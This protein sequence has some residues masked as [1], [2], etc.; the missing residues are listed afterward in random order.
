MTPKPAPCP[1]LHPAFQKSSS[2]LSA[3]N[4]SW[5]FYVCVRP[6]APLTSRVCTGLQASFW[7]PGVQWL[8][9]QRGSLVSVI[10]RCVPIA[11]VS[12]KLTALV[13]EF[14]PCFPEHLGSPRLRGHFPVTQVNP[15]GLSGT[16]LPFHVELSL[17]AAS[18]HF[19][20]P[21]ASPE[22]GQPRIAHLEHRGLLAGLHCCE[23]LLYTLVL[24]DWDQFGTINRA[25]SVKS[26]NQ[27]KKKCNMYT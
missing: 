4:V 9:K 24:C 6:F 8:T 17:L 11:F 23:Y 14:L 10:S 16:F 20:F 7:V 3:E 13:A 2:Q 25:K 15:R 27:K 21:L 1:D 26:G 22:P 19:A 12:V 5:T 18:V